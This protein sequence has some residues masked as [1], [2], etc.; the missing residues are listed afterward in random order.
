VLQHSFHK[1]QGYNPDRL[2]D[3]LIEHMNLK[4]DAALARLLRVRHPI[5]SKVRNRRAPVTAALLLR[6][7]EA[8]LV[9]VQ[10]LRKMMGVAK[11]C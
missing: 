4:N 8:T 3:S 6:M 2:F 1:E 5:I 10:Q 11:A 9:P 7:H